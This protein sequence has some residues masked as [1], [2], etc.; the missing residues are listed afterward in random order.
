M[1]QLKSTKITGDLSVSGGI[2]TN[3][4]LTGNNLKIEG[5]QFELYGTAG[6]PTAYID[7]HYAGDTSDYTSRIIESSSGELNINGMKIANIITQALL[8]IYQ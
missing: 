5:G 3:S 2:T 4:L 6:I 7:F 8:Q 1:A